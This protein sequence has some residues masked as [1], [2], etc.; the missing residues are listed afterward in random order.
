MTQKRL[1]ESII[2]QKIEEDW[3]H[4]CHKYFTLWGFFRKA[5]RKSRPMIELTPF[6][7]MTKK[8]NNT[9]IGQSHQERE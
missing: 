3:M 6:P 8:Q 9:N 4:I 7:F 1:Y 5:A 2:P